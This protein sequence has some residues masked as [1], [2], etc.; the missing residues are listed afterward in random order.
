MIPIAQDLENIF[1]GRNGP[2]LE[3]KSGGA[4]ILIICVRIIALKPD[5]AVIGINLQAHDVQRGNLFQIIFGDGS[6]GNAQ[7]FPDRIFDQ[8]FLKCVDYFRTVL[9]GN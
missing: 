2:R 7:N 3:I 8:W 4:E 6:I 9:F 5:L 1:Q